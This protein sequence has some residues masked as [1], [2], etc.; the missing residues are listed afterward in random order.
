M[1]KFREELIVRSLISKS[2]EEEVGILEFIWVE[3]QSFLGGF[4]PVC[5]RERERERQRQRDR[6]EEQ[7][8]GNGD[9]SRN[10]D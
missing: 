3:G 9:V 4:L 6:R 10:E 8:K 7:G 1:Q 2:D 5:E